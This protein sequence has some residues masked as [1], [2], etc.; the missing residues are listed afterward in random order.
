MRTL[1]A[2]Y[3]KTEGVKVM[4]FLLAV[5]PNSLTLTCSQGRKRADHGHW[6]DGRTNQGSQVKGRLRSCSLSQKKE[7]TFEMNKL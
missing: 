3:K 4:K 7:E 2:Y 6:S 5:I 1:Y